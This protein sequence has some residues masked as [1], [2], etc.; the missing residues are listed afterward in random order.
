MKLRTKKRNLNDL[1]FY[2]FNLTEIITTE[3]ESKIDDELIMIF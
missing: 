1:V 3:N 2:L